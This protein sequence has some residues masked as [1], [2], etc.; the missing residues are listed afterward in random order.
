[1]HQHA[2]N[3]QTKGMKMGNVGNEP[4][5]S[6]LL[7]SIDM[8]RQHDEVSALLDNLPPDELESSLSNI[9]LNLFLGDGADLPVDFLAEDVA[10]L[11]SCDSDEFKNFFNEKR[12]VKAEPVSPEK[13][14]LNRKA[15]KGFVNKKNCVMKNE[16]LEEERKEEIYSGISPGINV[17]VEDRIKCEI[18][19]DQQNDEGTIT[20]KKKGRKRKNSDYSKKKK[21]SKLSKN[22]KLVIKYK[23]NPSEEPKALVVSASINSTSTDNSPA[24]SDSMYSPS[25][26]FDFSF[27]DIPDSFSTSIAEKVKTRTRNRTSSSEPVVHNFI[28]KKPVNETVVKKIKKSPAEESTPLRKNSPCLSPK[29]VSYHINKTKEAIQKKLWAIKNLT[30]KNNSAKQVNNVPSLSLIPCNDVLGITDNFISKSKRT[31]I[32]N[33]V[34]ASK[35]KNFHDYSKSI[36]VNNIVVKPE[37][38]L[39]HSNLQLVSNECKPVTLR[40]DTNHE[41]NL[42]FEATTKLRA[43]KT[44]G[45]YVDIIS[46]TQEFSDVPVSMAEVEIASFEDVSSDI[47]SGNK[48]PYSLRNSHISDSSPKKPVVLLTPISSKRLLNSENMRNRHCSTESE[49]SSHGYHSADS[50]SPAQTANL[51]RTRRSGLKSNFETNPQSESQYSDDKRQEND[52]RKIPVDNRKAIEERRVMYVGKIPIGFTEEILQQRF[53]VF[54]E[55]ENIQ[56]KVRESEAQ[57]DCGSVVD[58]EYGDWSLMSSSNGMDRW[59]KMY[60]FVTF[61]KHSDVARAIEEGQKWWPEL[62]L[63]FGGRRE[64]V[65]VNYSDL[66]GNFAEKTGYS[67][68]YSPKKDDDFDFARELKA[69]QQRR[70]LAYK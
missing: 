43:R 14:I 20:H 51:F 65:K 45:E 63:N 35:I 67:Y 37:K 33:N 21:K 54:G 53:S 62:K 70:G 69:A 36:P 13:N 27:A 16:I 56:I 23:D 2:C 10:N 26:P 59:K 1:M 12:T 6:D 8:E 18:L 57:N 9:D 25:Q 7:F 44:S 55:I 31:V 4:R 61:K 58:H 15:K 22:F 5:L 38:E 64:F 34:I 40:S 19:S 49:N 32:N 46:S 52:S 39:N 17:K 60:G 30:E 68:G 48:S 50:L 24:Y 47:P 29:S 28:D 41:M 11:S 3:Q 66:D 42:L